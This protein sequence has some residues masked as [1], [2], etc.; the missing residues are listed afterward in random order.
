MKKFLRTLKSAGGFIWKRMSAIVAVGLIALALLIGYRLG[1]GREPASG[2]TA[3]A[4]AAAHAHGE[5]TTVYTCSMHPSVRVTD[6]DAKCPICFMDVV[7]VSDGAGEA[8]QARRITLSKAAARR[9]EVETAPVAR[10]FPQAQVR[11]TGKMTYDETSV[12]RITAYFPGRIERLFVNYVGVPVGEGE[13]LAEMYSPELLAAFEEI[14]QARIAVEESRGMS[15]LVRRSTER[16]L[17]AARDKLRLFGLTAEQIHAAETG[18]TSGERL[19]VYSPISGVVTDLSARE[20][21]YVETGARIATVADLSRL[22]LDLEAYESQLPLLRWGQPVTFT[23]EARPGER[24]EGRIAFIE[25]IVD[26][27]TRTAAVRV[28]VD[29]ADRVLKP[30]MFAS[31]TALA[32]VDAEGAVLSDALAGKWVGPMHPTVV[33]DEP[34]ACE[35]CGM[36]LVPAESLGVVGDPSEARP[37]LVIPR[38]AALLTGE[39]AVVYVEVE[40]AERRTYEARDVVLGPR[41]GSFYVVRTGLHEGERVVVNGAF[42]V[43]SAMQIAGKRG[44]MAPGDEAPGAA[45]RSENPDAADAEHGDVLERFLEEL[46]PVYAAYFSAQE[47]LAADDFA[48]FQRAAGALADAISSVDAVGLRPEQLRAWRSAAGRL[49]LQRPVE[50]VTEARARFERMSD[51]AIELQRRFGHAGDETWRLAYCPMAFGDTGA[52]WLQRG[53]Q[54]NNPYFGAVM[55]RCGEVRDAFPPLEGAAGSAHE[56]HDHE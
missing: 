49:R 25:P 36:D 14:R 10:F 43:D 33:E 13:H 4:P 54:I 38:S 44:M 3:E 22:W 37:P 9:S 16:T 18:E 34:G 1:D 40:G 47:T 31:A 5:E 48:G 12:A 56:A 45:D 50:D 39:R 28:A 35:V 52:D 2:P 32:L 29:N 21:D 20:G 7:P 53:A 8:D 46:T 30:G 55:L 51:A 15:D 42:R 41:A 6:P 26:E 17:D 24:F 11:L 19:T 27:R 23:V